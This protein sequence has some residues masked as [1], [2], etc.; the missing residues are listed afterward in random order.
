MRALL[1]TLVDPVT[2]RRGAY[3][4]VGAPLGLVW[5][6]ALITLW[7]LCLAL[8]ITPLAIP[9]LLALALATQAFARV[10]AAIAGALLGTATKGPTFA[11]PRGGIRAWLRQLFGSWFW[12]AQAHLW[13]RWILGFPVAVTLVALLAA[14]L[15][16]SFGPLWV[17]FVPGGMI[18]LGFWHVHTVLQSLALVPLGLI[19]LALVVALAHPLGGAFRPLAAALSSD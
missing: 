15:G 18:S 11:R 16:M 19:L 5:F 7:S 4:L 10:E 8:A 9:M 17:P 1:H 2:Y 3:L 6:V 14:A 13:A 12:R